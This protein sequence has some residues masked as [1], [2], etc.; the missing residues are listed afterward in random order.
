MMPLGVDGG[1]HDSDAVVVV[2]LSATGAACPA[3]PASC[4]V[5]DVVDEVVHPAV[6]HATTANE[7]VV[8]GAKPASLNDNVVCDALAKTG[9]PLLSNV[10]VTNVVL[11]Y[12]CVGGVH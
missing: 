7:Y 4:D 11:S 1:C 3:G 5:Y 2:T 6:L 8:Y 12:T 9:A 10:Y